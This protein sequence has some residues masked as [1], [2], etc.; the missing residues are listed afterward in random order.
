VQDEQEGNFITKL[1]RGNLDILPWPVIQSKEF[2]DLM[3]LLKDRL[4]N[5]EP[6]HG[7]ASMFLQTLKTLMAKLK[8][9]DWG[10]LDREPYFSHIV[11]VM[12]MLAETENLAGYRAQTLQAL[13]FNA[14]VFGV[15]ENDASDGQLKV[16]NVK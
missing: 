9:S 11:G 15:T 7:N 13:L 4:D 10:A 1:H 6:S 2:Y 5:Q 3:S 12:L 14:L 16:R 8:A